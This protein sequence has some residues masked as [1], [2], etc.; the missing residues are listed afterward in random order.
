MI[1]QRFNSNPEWGIPGLSINNQLQGLSELAWYVANKVAREF[2]D[3]E[4]WMLEIGSYMGESTQVFAYTGAFDHILAIDPHDGHE[5]FN[6]IFGYDWETVKREFNINT[7]HFNN[8]RLI[9]DYSYNVVDHMV[10]EGFHFI[11]I[12]GD[13]TYEGVKRDIE[14]M[15]PKV[16][17]G[18]FI[19]GHDFSAEHLGVIKAVHEVFQE[20][21]MTFYDESWLFQKL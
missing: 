3:E 20:E 1:T 6:D 8:I 14:M 16:K 5:E 21:P 18:G 11:Y 13:H 2:K 17:K 10:D 7:R 4:R 19:G 15:L 12:D 9:N